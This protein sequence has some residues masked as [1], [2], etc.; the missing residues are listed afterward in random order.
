[1]SP[2]RCGRAD[3]GRG[4]TLAYEAFGDPARP[5]LLVIM[6]LGM[7]L[8]GWPDPLVDHL[9]ARGFYVVRFD[10]RDTGLSTQL[11]GQRGTP[12][13]VAIL[14]ARLGLTVHAPYLL[15]DMA[16]DAIGLMDALRIER[17][18]VVG[19]SMGGM[20]AQLM[21][22]GFAPRLRS[23]VLV[24]TNSGDPAAGAPAW[25]ATAA[26]LKRPPARASVEQLVEHYYNVFRV[27]GSPPGP[28]QVP[29]DA[30]RER[31]RAT[32][33]RAW[34]PAG[35][36]RQMLAIVASGDRSRELRGLTTP[37][38]V[39]HGAVD[40]L[41]PVSSAHDLARKIPGAQLTI[42]EHMG[43]DLGPLERIGDE[44]GAFCARH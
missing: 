10:N 33:T 41:V 13:P 35:T 19:A 24:M 7:Q 29:D 39:L 1:M 31:M 27:I 9:V 18:H 34:R 25:S 44:I 17:A 2:H 12:L 21:A 6:G 42:I 36:Y 16:R 43:H 14:R 30:L 8:T 3:V 40:P 38:L 23:L 5:A 37:T 20:I 28:H 15:H 4:I 26:L 11:D 32:F 22:S